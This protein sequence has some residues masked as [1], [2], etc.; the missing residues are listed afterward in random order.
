MAALLL[1]HSVMAKP[2]RVLFVGNS[3][4]YVNDLPHQFLNVAQSLGEEVVVANSTIGGCTVYAQRPTVDNRTA[5]LLQEDWDFIVLQT[6]SSLPTVEAAR[7]DYLYPAIKS[8]LP[9]KKHAKIVM[10]LTWGYHDGNTAACPSS[11][12]PSC[13]PLGTLANLT[14]PS[15]LTSK[16]YDDLAGTF[17]CMGYAV[18]RGYIH[19]LQEGA[20]M[21]SP[22]GLAW[23]VVRA[24]NE[25]PQGC[26][27][28]VDA[29]YAEPFPLALP[30]MVAGGALPDMMLYRKFGE[31]IDKHPN[32]A[33]Q[34]LNALTFFST[35]FGGRSPVGAATPLNTG[36]VGAGDKPL[37]HAEMA[38]LQAVAHG[39]VMQCGSACGF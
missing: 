35:L 37:T 16:H 25:I 22:C 26:K 27:T 15:C 30:L 7:S 28:L 3:F 33:G 12:T 11:V 13:F 6:Y 1:F 17:P 8:F 14:S 24:V 19:A 32:E 21:V 31:R 29:Q 38:A 4:T 2:T 34:Y 10:Y 20:D 5:T 18:A 36:S 39:V 9:Y 23:Q